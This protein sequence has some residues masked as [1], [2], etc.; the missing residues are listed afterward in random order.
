[1]ADDFK[2]F[3]S[4]DELREVKAAAKRIAETANTLSL[5]LQIIK[6]YEMVLQKRILEQT[7]KEAKEAAPKQLESK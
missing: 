7:P 6:V 2:V 3:I 1:M 5:D 4:P